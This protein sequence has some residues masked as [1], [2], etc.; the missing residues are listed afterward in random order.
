[1]SDEKKIVDEKK[2]DSSSKSSSSG[3]K[4]SSSFSVK[5]STPAPAAKVKPL[6]ARPEKTYSFDQWAARRGVPTHHRG[7]MRAFVTN[8]KKPRTL[9]AW[10]VCFK[11]Y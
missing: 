6:P 4:K 3:S 1:M 9:E 11:D 2:E 7:G 5:K 10:D 8:H